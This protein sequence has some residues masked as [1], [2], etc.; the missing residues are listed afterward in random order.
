[1]VRLT[2]GLNMP[3]SMVMSRLSVMPKMYDK[4]HTG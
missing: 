3:I 1:M 4:I 2:E